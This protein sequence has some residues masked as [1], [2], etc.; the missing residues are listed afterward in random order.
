MWLA[1][2][3][4]NE[5][6]SVQAAAIFGIAGVGVFLTWPVWI[7]PP[8]LVLLAL[9]LAGRARARW[10]YLACAFAPIAIVAALHAF[11]RAES[12][13]IVQ[14]GGAAFSPTAS[15]FGWPFLLLSAAGS[16]LALRDR[17]SRVTVLLLA[18]V[19]LQ[20]VGLLVVARVGGAQ[21][22]HTWRSRCRTSPSIR[23]RLPRQ[24]A[25]AGAFQLLAR[26]AES[27][28]SEGWLKRHGMDVLAWVLVVACGAA[29]GARVVSM[30]RSV[31]AITE[32]M[33][34]AGRWARDHVQ[35]DCV[36]YLV[37]Q[38]STSVLVAPGCARQPDAACAGVGTACL[39]LSGCAGAV[40]Y[41]ARAFRWPS[42]TCR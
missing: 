10:R 22:R 11:G 18:A 17:A 4:W 21:I 37:L 5:R 35:P 41:R 42:P 40:D 30:P 26:V 9:A 8:I 28:V 13:A 23:W 14:T 6:P 27:A 19:A 33:Y 25:I 31:P 29:T 34:R 39:L 2:V 3:L 36:E 12:V 7:G 15:R 1:L 20:T 32:D 16:V 24:L 38:D